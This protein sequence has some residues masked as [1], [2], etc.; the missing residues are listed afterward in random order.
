[1][2][3]TNEKLERLLNKA[4]QMNNYQYFVIFVFLIQIACADFFNQCL[5]FLERGPYVYIENSNESV[6]IDNMMC[7]NKS[8]HYI[9]DTSKRT[10]SIVMDFGIFCNETKKFYLGLILYLGIIIGYCSSYLFI[11]KIGRKKT[12]IIFVPIYTFFLCSFKILIPSLGYFCLYLIYVNIFFV[13]MC[14]HIIIITMFIYICEIIKQSDIPIIVI[15]IS[16]GVPLS[17]ILGTLLF[18]IKGFDWRNCLLIIAGINAIIY[19]FIYWKLVGSPIFALNNELFDAFIFDLIEL[20]QRNGIKLTLY[21]FEFLNPYMTQKHIQSIQ[22]KFTNRYNELNS[23]LLDKKLDD[24][25]IMEDSEEDFLS[26]IN[27]LKIF[28][29]SSLKDDYILSS[30][31]NNEKL[32]GKLKMKDYSPLDLIRF[33]KQIK[34]FFSCFIYLVMRILNNNNI[35]LCNIT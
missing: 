20:G 3:Q 30:E 33:R 22:S 28:N 25:S 34:N 4:G 15:I 9:I 29:K 6:I 7:K 5:P 17:N 27:N 32:F 18:N 26:S 35:N 16:S 10:S 31:E 14:G 23:N 13:G 12:L 2:K 1:M 11:D 8:I 19:I 21:D 24:S